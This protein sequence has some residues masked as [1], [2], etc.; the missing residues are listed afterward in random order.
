M[1]P[2]VLFRDFEERDIDFIY[3]CKNDKKLNS[4]IVGEWHPFTYEEAVKWV[5]GCMGEHSTYKFWAICTN[6]DEKRIIGWVSLSQIDH[7]AK[8]ACHHGI[9]IADSAYRDGTAYIESKDFI[10]DYVFNVLGFLKLTGACL[11]EHVLSRAA[12]EAKYYSLEYID[13]YAV[14]KDG[15]YHDVYHY[16]ILRNVYMDHLRNGDYDY[17]RYVRRLNKSIKGIKRELKE[18]L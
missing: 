6:D 14:I 16:Y 11:K 9:V 17:I 15:E 1:E 4:M 2:T 5:H 12:M 3:K 10:Y 13:K 7:K 8:S 18:S